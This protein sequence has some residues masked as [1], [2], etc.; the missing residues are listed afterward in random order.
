MSSSHRC[1]VLYCVTGDD[2]SNDDDNDLDDPGSSE[3]DDAT[4]SDLL[5]I[6]DDDCTSTTSSISTDTDNEIV[7]LI[8]DNSGN[9][10]VKRAV[11]KRGCLD[12][13]QKVYSK[14]DEHRE[15]SPSRGLHRLD[16]L[17]AQEDETTRQTLITVSA[18]K[19]K[20]QNAIAAVS[21]S[22]KKFRADNNVQDD[23]VKVVD[24]SS[25]SNKK[26]SRELFFLG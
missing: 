19:R 15:W 9:N 18:K 4:Q 12:S 6:D 23:V 1:T 22:D 16:K 10:V 21:S 8:E 25:P 11:G 14:G 5:F 20:R 3:S 7:H 2:V 13:A 17:Q 26:Y 24:V